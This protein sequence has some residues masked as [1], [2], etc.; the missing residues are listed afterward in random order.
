MK[1][2]MTLKQQMWANIF[3]C[4]VYR[5]NEYF[6]QGDLDRHAREHTTAILALQKGDQFWK[7][8]L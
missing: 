7:E 4:A 5:S 2:R 3:K 6:D 1:L 8:F